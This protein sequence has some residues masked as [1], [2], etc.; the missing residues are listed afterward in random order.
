MN[1]GKL[2]LQHTKCPLNLLP[3]SFLSF[4]KNSVG[5]LV[6]G[7]LTVFTNAAHERIDTFGEITPVGK[8]SRKKGS[9]Y[10]S[11]TTMKMHTRFD[12]IIKLI[13]VEGESVNII[14][15]DPHS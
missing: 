2:S 14:G 4:G 1:N 8:H 15:A 11:R 10:M 9:T 6:S 7:L 13:A 12:L 5:F 3:A